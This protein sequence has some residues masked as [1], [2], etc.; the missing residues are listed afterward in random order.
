V[1][2]YEEETNLRAHSA[3]EPQHVLPRAGPR[4]AQIQ[5]SGG[6]GLTTLFTWQR[7]AVGLVTFG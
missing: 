3:D 4:Q 5:Y 1:K 7:D 6:G 2:R